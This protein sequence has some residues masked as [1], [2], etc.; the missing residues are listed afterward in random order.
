MTDRA[1]LSK[2]D[3]YTSSNGATFLGSR[4]FPTALVESCQKWDP[5]G[6]LF[7]LNGIQAEP[8]PDEQARLRQILDSRL[9]GKSLL[10]CSGGADKLVPYHAS[11][12]F[13]EF[14]KKATKGWYSDGNIYVED[15]VYDGVGHAYSDGMAEDS[16]R[17]L[18][19]LLEGKDM[20]GMEKSRM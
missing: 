13:M 19:D 15:N 20:T 6:L 3:T 4:D 2:L 8:S 14:L 7:G 5:R 12:P 9:K 17:F 18:C 10:V 16:G 1:R 11:A